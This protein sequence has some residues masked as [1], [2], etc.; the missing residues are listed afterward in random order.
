MKHILIADMCSPA[1]VAPLAREY[2]LGV[3]IDIFCTLRYFRN[4]PQLL[5]ER[6]E[7]L[8]HIPVRT[9][10]GPYEEFDASSTDPAIRSVT[11]AIADEMSAFGDALG[12]NLQIMHLGLNE[13]HEDLESV[14]SV[15]SFWRDFM[16]AQPHSFVLHLENGSECCPSVVASTVDA[17]E[18]PRVDVCLDL[19]HAHSESGVTPIKW[20]TALKERIGHFHLSDNHGDSDEHLNLGDGTI[21]WREVLDAAETLCPDA[22]W[23]L[24]TNQL[25][26]VR[27]VEFLVRHGYVPQP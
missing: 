4:N 3:E 11:R 23:T 10:H 12:T 25:D 20:I 26:V 27:S 16:S 5:P 9:L 14:A 8:A 2:G 22:T 17:I 15:V 1:R 13:K 18:D 7:A 21:S 24:E 6:I 19:G